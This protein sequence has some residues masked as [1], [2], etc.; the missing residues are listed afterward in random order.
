MGQ[1]IKEYFENEVCADFIIFL[2]HSVYSFLLIYD[3]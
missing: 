2:F 1:V 3:S